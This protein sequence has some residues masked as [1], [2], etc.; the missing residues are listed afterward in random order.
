MS[1]RNTF[2]STTGKLFITAV[3]L[4][5]LGGLTQLGVRSVLAAQSAQPYFAE[6]AAEPAP[7]CSE[8]LPLV[9]YLGEGAGE[10]ILKDGYDVFIVKQRQPFKF[11]LADGT[12]NAD[13]E[14]VF[15]APRDDDRVWIC[16]GDCN[17]PSIYHDAYDLGN[18]SP[19]WVVN[20]LVIDDDGLEQNNDQRRNWWAAANPKVPYLI[21]E[22][23][24]M[25]EYLSLEIPFEA[26]WY[27]YAEDS[28]GIVSTCIEPVTPTPTPTATPTSTPTATPTD[29]PTE[30]PPTATPTATPTEVATETPTPTPTS[31]EA[32]PVETPPVETPT[33]TPTATPS[34][35][36]PVT[37]TD[38]PVQPTTEAP[39]PTPTPF[40]APPTAI[41]LGSFTGIWEDDVV[42]IRWVTSYEEDTFGYRLYRSA[43]GTRAN[44]EL[45]TEQL[46][47]SQGTLGGDYSVTDADAHEG[48][49][50]TY[51]LEE[52]QVD[53]SASDV[54]SLTLDTLNERIFLPYTTRQ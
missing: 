1:F 41:E 49:A 46:V 30:V 54:A 43:D 36:V 2:L 4:L 27:Y 47:A 35:T 34:P 5:I 51:W 23:Q 15:T 11:L 33:A 20:L 44:A 32:P 37:V 31:T 42:V 3:S 14:T 53:G 8:T 21:V 12:V 18:L 22:D 45:V 26:Q 16:S 9:E 7:S 10:Y 6:N 50:Y 52:V 48:I 17:I 38:E 39:T 29:V 24:Q 40:V 28:I 19:G 25:V 13:G